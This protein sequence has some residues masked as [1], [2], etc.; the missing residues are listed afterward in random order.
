MTNKTILSNFKG[1]E[2]T[3][4]LV[5]EQLRSRWG[6]ELAD[7]FDPLRHVMTYK[8]W[9]EAGRFVK[10]NERALRSFVIVE[11]KDSDGSVKKYRRPCFLFHINQTEEKA[12]A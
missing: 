1:S 6:D 5:Q 4:A 11:S 9:L 7:S 12:E 8:K 2:K 3:K 10:K